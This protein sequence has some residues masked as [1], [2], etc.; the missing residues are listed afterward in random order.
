MTV[1]EI[2]RNQID[3]IQIENN[4]LSDI[5]AAQ[6]L[7]SPDWLNKLKQGCEMMAIPAIESNLLDDVVKKS[8]LDFID[9][10]EKRIASATRTIHAQ[11]QRNGHILLSNEQEPNSYFGRYIKHLSDK[12]DDKV[13]IEKL[14]QEC[15]TIFAHFPIRTAAQEKIGLVIGQVQ[16]GKTSCFNGLIAASMDYGFNVV[17]ILSG[18]IESL[19]KQT[20]DRLESDIIKHNN[21]DKELRAL[22]VPE[23][24]GLI[25]LQ[26]KN[27]FAGLNGPNRPVVYGV[28]LKNTK[29]LTNLKSFI[30]KAGPI[31]GKQINALIID[32]ECDEATPNVAAPPGISPTNRLIRE[33]RVELNNCCYIGFTAT[34][35]ANILNESGPGTLYP[36]DFMHFLPTPPKY[37]GPL[38]LFGNP[39]KSED[40]QDEFIPID[41]IRLLTNEDVR[42]LT[43]SRGTPFKPKAPNGLMKSIY[44]FICA[45]ACRISIG[46]EGFS[47]ML[48]HRSSQIG[49]QRPI[50]NLLRRKLFGLNETNKKIG[51]GILTDNIPELIENCKN[52]WEEEYLKVTPEKFAASFPE[53]GYPIERLPD[54]DLIRPSIA[55]VIEVITVKIDNSRSEQDERIEYKEGSPKIQIAVGGNTLSRG[56]TLEGLVCSFFAR[57]ASSFDS[58]LQMGRWFGFKKGF[59]LLPRIWTTPILRN[60]YLDL[61]SMELSL[62]NEIIE[63]YRFRTPSD[64]AVKLLTRPGFVLTRRSAMRSA[65]QYEMDYSNSSPQTINFNNDETKLKKNWGLGLKFIGDVFSNGKVGKQEKGTIIIN[66]VSFNQVYDFLENYS[67]SPDSIRFVKSLIL[68]FIKI[69]E[70]QYQNWT[71]VI[72]GKSD[73]P[74]KNFTTP[75]GS[76]GYINR[77]RLKNSDIE[78]DDSIPD[79]INIKAL[80]SSTDIMI[81]RPDLAMGITLRE[82]LW[83]IRSDNKLNPMLILYPIDKDSI[84]L[85]RDPTDENPERVNLNAAYNILGLAIVFNPSA[86]NARGNNYVI[87]PPNYSF[88]TDPEDEEE[89]VE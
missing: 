66:S 5:Q 59:E 52:I 58:L 28:F 36:K 68:K 48:I 50:Y 16:S 13:A 82:E 42:A 18:K 34:P 14:T 40:E 85:R 30:V 3:K 31:L 46:D 88:G 56:L 54:W 45:S 37:F 21:S 69:N 17:F 33:L 63:K 44:W 73:S 8:V 62:R 79:T 70:T 61:V 80:M 57:Q 22:S 25:F 2:I 26:P 83:K 32:D 47:S 67:D 19:R 24:P 49:H 72:A 64:V 39:E 89:L 43:P 51:T 86:E 1:F 76:V 53:Y 9:Q 74:P 41:V 55:K 6:L 81:D 7:N 65:V 15:S 38:Q 87:A 4:S 23:N 27:V 12:W 29:V 20:Q 78:T 71:V 11:V 35:F 84:P 60:G 75:Y 10:L 77:S